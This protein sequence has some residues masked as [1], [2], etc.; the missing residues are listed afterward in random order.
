MKPGVEK[1]LV[2]GVV[3]VAVL[4]MTLYLQPD[5]NLEPSSGAVTGERV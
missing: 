5:N 1:W 2:W 4:W 3:F